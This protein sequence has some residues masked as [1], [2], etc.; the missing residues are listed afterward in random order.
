MQSLMNIKAY[1]NYSTKSMQIAWKM[2][3]GLSFKIPTD[4]D[5]KQGELPVFGLD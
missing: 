4:L 3:K 2:N 5:F 1:V